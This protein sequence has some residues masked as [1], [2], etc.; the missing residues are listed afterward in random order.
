MHKRNFKL[1]LLLLVLI[2]GLQYA[3]FA[4]PE[5]PSPEADWYPPLEGTPTA[6]PGTSFAITSSSTPS[7]GNIRAWLVDV[8]FN[9]RREFYCTDYMQLVVQTTFSNFY[10]WVYEWYPNGVG[11]WLI[12]MLGPISGP[13]TIV[14]R[15]FRPEPAEPEGLHTWKIWLYDTNTGSWGVYVINF[16]YRTN[17]KARLAIVNAQ[18]SLKV[19]KQYTFTIRVENLGEVKW[20]YVV[21][22]ISSGVSVTP[23]S[24]EIS[25]DPQSSANIDFIVKPEQPGSYTIEFRVLSKKCGVRIEDS[26]T[27]NVN[28]EVLKPGPFKEGDITPTEV[29][30]GE[31]TTFTVLFVNKGSGT[32]KNVE[33]R[34]VEAQGF[35]IIKGSDSSPD[36]PSGAYGHAQIIL[37]PRE[38][39]LKQIKVKVTYRDEVGKYY[40]DTL[41]YQV[42][43]LSYLGEISDIKLP[44]TLVIQKAYTLTVEV[45]NTGD[46]DCTYEVRVSSNLPAE[47]MPKSQIVSVSKGSSDIAEFTIKPVEKG[48][49]VLKVELYIKHLGKKVDSK[50]VSALAKEVSL[51]LQEVSQSEIYVNEKGYIKVTL[52]NTGDLD[53]NALIKVTIE[54][55]TYEETKYIPAGETIEVSIPVVCSKEGDIPVEIQVLDKN[56]G[57][58]LCT[59]TA[60][61]H[62]KSKLIYWIAGITAVVAIVIV[63]LALMYYKRKKSTTLPLPPPPP[64]SS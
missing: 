35:D 26:K 34:V 52:R 45:H 41:Y 15:Y 49:L 53:V 3:A 62:V 11:H 23:S 4:Q 39:G 30:E 10:L 1:M 48:T 16:N 8:N 19:G 37:K 57:L 64:P 17:P 43:V 7:S 40:E 59:S 6:P 36:I 31:E 18:Y 25:I 42:K 61:I 44:S 63:I 55:K 20:T 13:G 33:I 32:A 12:Y 47:I 51:K 50:T 58:I 5:P 46:L 28:V 22:A 38:G 14:V 24:K 54:G 60:A 27:V 56:T 2:V 29:R 21:E 9:V